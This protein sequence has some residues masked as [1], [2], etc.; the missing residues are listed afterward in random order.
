M[1]NTLKK[2]A[3]LDR[4]FIE[5]IFREISRTEHAVEVLTGLC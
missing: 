3:I 4:V 1:A 5:W 2:A